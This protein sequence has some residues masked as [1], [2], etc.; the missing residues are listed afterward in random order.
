MQPSHRSLQFRKMRALIFISARG[1]HKKQTYIYY[2]ELVM[3]FRWDIDLQ[4]S[5]PGSAI[6]FCEEG[7]LLPSLKT[8]VQFLILTWWKEKTRNKFCKLPSDLCDHCDTGV[9]PA[10]HP[11]NTK[12][13]SGIKKWKREVLNQI[14][15]VKL[16][17][18]REMDGTEGGILILKSIQTHTK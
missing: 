10:T 11:P 16:K 8:Y 12:I 5:K 4:G 17:R 7:C 1:K 6:W 14:L 15:L 13:V 2:L 3:D 18:V 9:V